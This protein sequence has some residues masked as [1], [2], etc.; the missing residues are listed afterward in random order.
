MKIPPSDLTGRSRTAWATGSL[1]PE[2]AAGSSELHILCHLYRYA[3]SPVPAGLGTVTAS[4]SK[5]RTKLIVHFIRH[6]A[7]SVPHNDSFTGHEKH[8]V[9]CGARVLQK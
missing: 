3:M 4:S 5:W 1:V 9:L 6:M 7:C 2:N 8:F